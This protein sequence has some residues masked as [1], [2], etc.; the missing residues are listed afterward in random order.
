MRIVSAAGDGLMANDSTP[1]FRLVELAVGDPSA[2]FAR[3]VAD[4]LTAAPKRLACRYFYDR[5]GSRLFEAICK[6][7]EYYLT[8]AEAAILHDHAQEIADGF[9]ADATVIELGSGTAVKTQLLLKALLRTRRRVRYVPIDI[10]RPVLEESSAGL[11]QKFPGLEIVAVAAEYHEGLE[12]LASESACP[13]LILWLGSNIGNFDRT[14]A[15]AFLRR[16]HNT[17]QPD[18]RM[19]V[20]FDLRKER[21]VLEAAYDDAAGVTAAFNLN[22]LARINRE[23][24]GDFDLGAFR[25]RAIYDPG[26]GRIEMYLVSTRSQRVTIGR[27]GLQIEFA[28]GETI[29]T[30]NSYKYSLREMDVVSKSAGLQA[31]RCWQDAEGRFSLHLLRIDPAER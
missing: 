30:E 11:L 9:P 15:A 24:D 2:E 8:R 20:G 12:R 6:L 3:D 23:L 29:H 22:L 27:L 28:A 26:L 13:K 19:L 18:D 16:I 10:C 5:E 31:E 4:G 1:S 7:P 21:A 17:L 25:H 14:E